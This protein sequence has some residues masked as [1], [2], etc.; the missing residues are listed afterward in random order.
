MLSRRVLALLA[1][2]ALAAAGVAPSGAVFSASSTNPAN[3][4]TAAADWVAPTVTLTDPGSPLH[5]TV[6]LA[7]VAADL[8]SGVADV[9]FQAARAG[10]A[11]WTDL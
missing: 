7:A 8:G 6:T 11:S 2:A 9:R 3:R 5:G 4:L 1:L 10:S